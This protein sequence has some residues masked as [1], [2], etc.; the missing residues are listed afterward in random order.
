[1]SEDREGQAFQVRS[2]P[3]VFSGARHRLSA[4][5]AQAIHREVG[6]LP[7]GQSPL[8]DEIRRQ[9]DRALRDGSRGL[10]TDEQA[11]TVLAAVE[12][13]RLRAG[14]LPADL[15]RLREG[16]LRAQRTAA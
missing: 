5:A 11:R 1:M 8:V 14:R 10:F 16:L 6:R 7:Q 2:V 3:F 9:I 13:I 4:G 15:E 12:R